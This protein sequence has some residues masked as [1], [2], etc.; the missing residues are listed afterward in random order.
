[1]LLTVKEERRASAEKAGALRRRSSEKSALLS[2]AR[3][4]S[5]N[6]GVFEEHWTCEK[7]TGL[8]TTHVG[9]SV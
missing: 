3:K 7:R 5:K 9:S 6:I 4:P 8:P 1:M 2:R